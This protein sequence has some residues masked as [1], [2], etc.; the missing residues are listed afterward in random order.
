M[1]PA[2]L[3]EIAH[4]ASI[5]YYKRLYALADQ[6]AEQ[7]QRFELS[8]TP[9]LPDQYEYPYRSQFV[10]NVRDKKPRTQKHVIRYDAFNVLL[11]RPTTGPGYSYRAITLGPVDPKPS[12]YPFIAALT[13]QHLGATEPLDRQHPV[14][15]RLLDSNSLFTVFNE[16][17]HL[18]KTEAEDDKRPYNYGFILKFVLDPLEAWLP[19][20]HEY[21]KNYEEILRAKEEL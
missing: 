11:V 1:P 10:L 19:T 6:F 17:Y 21:L 15:M 7:S 8:W 4:M 13:R 16:H 5:P 18:I 2:K 14:D 12:I 20:L 9:P 3:P